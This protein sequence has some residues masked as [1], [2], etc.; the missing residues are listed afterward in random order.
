MPAPPSYPAPTFIA[1]AARSGSTLLRFLV[2][3]HPDMACPPETDVALVARRTLLSATALYGPGAAS[4]P[5]VLDLARRTVEELL[6]PFVA[7][8]GAARWCDKS[9][10]NADH[11]GTLAAVWPDAHFVL[12]HRHCMDVVASAVEAS[13]WGLTGYGLEA[14]AATNPSNSV[15]ALSRYWVDRTTQLLDFES[16]HPDRCLRLTYEDLVADPETA[17]ARVWALLEVDPL[18][19]AATAAFRAPHV[20]TG[21]G[22][23]KIWYTDRIEPGS[24]G[25]GRRVPA[26]L[27]P[28]PM[29]DI[30]NRLLAQLGYEPVDAATWGGPDGDG[31]TGAGGGRSASGAPGHG[32]GRVELQVTE[33]ASVRWRVVVDL[34]RGTWEVPGPGGAAGQGPPPARVAIDAEAFADLCAGAENIGTALRRRSVRPRGMALSTPDEER[35][36]FGRLAA[37]LRASGPELLAHLPPPSPPGQ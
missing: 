31:D 28:A 25:R 19:D 30:V 12:L 16:R 22:D 37:V 8:A 24:V 1:C 7:A 32:G 4:D 6:A 29:L 18:P 10:T 15:A 17:M 26:H 5:A 36:T 20:G 34:D 35:A 14:Y 27:V 13:P 23:F 9:L 11:L 33:G 2:D 21:S 3:A